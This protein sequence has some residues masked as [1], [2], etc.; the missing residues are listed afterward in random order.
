MNRP[1]SGAA[2]HTYM[3]GTKS[4]KSM[5]I[6]ALRMT[7]FIRTHSPLGKANTMKTELTISEMLD[8]T[9]DQ[10]E[11]VLLK[12]AGELRDA[13]YQLKR[14]KQRL[15]NAERNLK[16]AREVVADFE[17]LL[18]EVETVMRIKKNQ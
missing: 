15:A 11:L 2:K 3:F 17:R 13:Q 6:I 10:C 5:S 12:R 9:F 4:K 18:T 1:L 8:L 16:N 7:Y 14:Q